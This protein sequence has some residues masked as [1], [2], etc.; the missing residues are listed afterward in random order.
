MRKDLLKFGAA[1]VVMLAFGAAF[2][3]NGQT[4]TGSIAGGTAARGKKARATVVLSI[5]SGLHTNSSRPG[6]EYAIA[7]SVKATSQSGVKIGSVSYPRGTNRKFEFA[8]KPLNVYEGRV[9][10]G[11]DVTVPSTFK[12]NSVKVNV[13]VRYQACTNE[14][15]YPPK[16][17]AITLTAKVI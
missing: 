6:G 15:C 7:T 12:G 4:V 2:A 11:F 17:K 5:P 16:S 13:T 9:P 3:M 8:E 1:A 14:V 10:F